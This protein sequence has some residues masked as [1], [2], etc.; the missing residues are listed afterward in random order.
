MKVSWDPI[1][2]IASWFPSLFGHFC[3]DSLLVLLLSQGAQAKG[4]NI[5]RKGI[6]HVYSWQPI[7]I[8]QSPICVHVFLCLLSSFSKNYWQRIPYLVQF[9]TGYLA[10]HCI[11]FAKC[12]LNLVWVISV[13]MMQLNISI[14]MKYDVQFWLNIDTISKC[15]RLDGLAGLLTCVPSHYSLIT[16]WLLYHSSQV[17]RFLQL[18][19]LPW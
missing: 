1:V 7:L 9:G 18:T 17:I 10:K 19:I 8:D 14:W 15:P 4:L 13:F 2:F 3:P 11:Q 16:S 12:L 5:F 6:Y